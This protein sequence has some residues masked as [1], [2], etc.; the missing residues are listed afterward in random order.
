ML[1]FQF[2]TYVIQQ[3][4]SDVMD[5]PEKQS[6][7]LWRSNVTGPFLYFFRST[8]ENSTNRDLEEHGV[9]DIE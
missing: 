9:R 6:N 3:F 8:M 5:A 7:S 2:L 4:K 1:K